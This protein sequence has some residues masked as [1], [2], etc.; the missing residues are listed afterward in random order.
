VSTQRPSLRDHAVRGQVAPQGREAI[1]TPAPPQTATVDHQPSTVDRSPSTA[2]WEEAHRR[3]TFYC[4]L[5]LLRALESEM[6]RSRRS[7]TAVIVDAIREHLKWGA[8]Q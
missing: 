7:K 6:D 1:Y 8:S 2:T 3:V 4:P 5:D